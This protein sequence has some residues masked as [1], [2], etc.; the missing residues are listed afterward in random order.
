LQKVT[1]GASF[2]NLSLMS[3]RNSSRKRKNCDQEVILG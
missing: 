1:K 2:R 3:S